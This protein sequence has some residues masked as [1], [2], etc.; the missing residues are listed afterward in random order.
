MARH[1]HQ[2]QQQ[3]RRTCQPL[4]C[5]GSQE[6]WRRARYMLDGCVLVLVPL[7]SRSRQAELSKPTCTTVEGRA[8]SRV[9]CVCFPPDVPSSLSRMVADG[10]CSGPRADWQSMDD[11]LRWR[12]QA[13]G[14]SFVA[15]DLASRETLEEGLDGPAQL[16]RLGAQVR[17]GLPLFSSGTLLTSWA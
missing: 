10:R 8:R 2:R 12:Y 6:P 3:S 15:A 1:R 9:E 5:A 17:R 11:T 16:A 7:S 13:L 14:D 4:S